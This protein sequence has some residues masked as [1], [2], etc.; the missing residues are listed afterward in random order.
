VLALLVIGSFWISRKGPDET[1]GPTPGLDLELDYALTD[2][3]ILS[4]DLQGRPAYLLRAPRFT[5]DASTGQGWISEPQ[6]EV[7]NQGQLWHIIADAATVTRDRERVRLEGEVDLYRHGPKRSDWLAMSSSEVTL[8]VTPRLA[9]STQ[10]VEL[11][12]AGSRMTANG[13]SVDMLKNTYLLQ[14]DVKGSYAV[15]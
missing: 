9:W 7:H 13:F 2:F 4:F 14:S 15:Q 5:S 11:M 1:R 8:E 3:E 10:F 6:I 12:D